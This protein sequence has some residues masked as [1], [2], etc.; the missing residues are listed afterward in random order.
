MP[1][2]KERVRLLN[3][4]KR[5]ITDPQFH[6]HYGAHMLPIFVQG[7]FAVHLSHKYS[8]YAFPFGC[9]LHN[10]SVEREFDW[11]WPVRDMQMLREKMFHQLEQDLEFGRTFRE[12]YLGAF[13]SFV[14]A[15]KEEERVQV[16]DLSLEQIVSRLLRLIDLAGRQ[17]IGYAVDALLTTADDDWFPIWI[18]RYST[19][20]LTAAQ[21]D[22]LHQP[23]RPSFVNVYRLRLLEAAGALEKGEEVDAALQRIVQDFYWVENNYLQAQPKSFAHIEQ[24]VRAMIGAREAYQKEKERFTEV[25][26]QRQKILDEI[27]ASEMLRRFVEF[28]DDCAYIQDCRKEAVLRL[29]HFIFL[30][31][32]ELAKRTGFDPELVMCVMFFELEDFIKDP[33]SFRETAERRRQGALSLVDKDGFIT[34]PRDELGDVDVSVLFHDYSDVR[35]AHGTPASLGSVEGVARIVLGGDQFSEFQD[36][37]I[38]ITNQ[39]TPDF[40]P[41]MHRAAAIVAEQGGLT[42]HAA[43]ISRELGIPCV[44]GVKD[45]MQIFQTG[46]RVSVDAKSGLVKKI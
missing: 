7:F 13:H 8:E 41:I 2:Q 31:V 4:F 27:G 36:G 3:Y 28:T 23:T 38:L 35:E 15:A 14:A 26:S 12:Q 5:H 9:C 17:G 37:E 10:W 40:V 42:S 24:E 33:N 6:K 1:N 18:Q 32:S 21:I 16:T 29:N 19:H 44:V 45:A 43:V 22:T 20:K 30:S 11:L 25:T 39:T 46:E 34:I